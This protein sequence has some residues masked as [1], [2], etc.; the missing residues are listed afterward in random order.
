MHVYANNKGRVCALPSGAQTGHHSASD[1][2]K[3]CSKASQANQINQVGCAIE[4]SH[5]CGPDGAL[6]TSTNKALPC[7]ASKVAPQIAP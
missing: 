2:A 1:P 5:T 3:N 4:P 7:V 6:I